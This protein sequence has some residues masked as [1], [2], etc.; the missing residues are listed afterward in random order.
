MIKEA[1]RDSIAWDEDK[2]I[3]L[4]RHFDRLMEGNVK[5]E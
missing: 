4:D 3:S 1:S 5:N 2:I